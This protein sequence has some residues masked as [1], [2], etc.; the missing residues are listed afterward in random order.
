[1]MA[2]R[3]ARRHQSTQAVRW[4]NQPTRD[5]R[6]SESKSSTR[7]DRPRTATPAT[8]STPTGRATRIRWRWW[9]TTHNWAGTT[10]AVRISRRHRSPR[11]PACSAGRSARRVSLSA[12]ASPRRSTS[13][14]GERE[15]RVWLN[16][17]HLACQL[18]KATTDEVI[19]RN[20]QLHLADSA[21]TWLEHL[22]TSQIHNW[23][24]LVRT[25]VGNFQVTYV[26]PGNSRDL[27]ACTQKPGESL[28]DFIRRFS[29]RCT[30]LLSVAQSQWSSRGV[31]SGTTSR[32]T[33][34]QWSPHSRWGD[35]SQPGR[36]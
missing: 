15:P 24:D 14:R 5:E 21:R 7:V 16:D 36:G 20:L 19:I 4:D 11:G 9:T 1:M 25:F 33:R 22:P 6:R 17:Y 32:P 8:S 13:T 2:A 26:C 35:H 31:S 30:E 34:L 23:D 12:S 3:R 10:I 29:K 28:R 18:G 27:C